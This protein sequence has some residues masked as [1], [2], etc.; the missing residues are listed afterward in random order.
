MKTKY[1][2]LDEVETNYG[3]VYDVPIIFP[4]S[5]QHVFVAEHFG[6]KDNVGSAGFVDVG[7]NGDGKVEF[8]THGESISLKKTSKPSDKALVS[9]VFKEPDYYS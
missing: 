8:H 4:E 1:I 6:G 7:V 9:R 5:L 3:T 2:I